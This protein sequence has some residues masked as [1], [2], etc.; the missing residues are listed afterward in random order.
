MKRTKFYEV[1]K[2][3]GAKLIEYGGFEM[4]VQ[5]S[6]IITEHKSVRNSVGIFDVSHMGEIFVLGEN[7]LDFVQEIAINDV[8]KLYPG[9]VQYSA[10]CKPNGGIIDDLLVYRLG[11]NEFMLVVNASNTDKDFQWMNSNIKTGVTLEN[12]S[13]EYSLLAVQ[14]PCSKK[15]IQKL[16]NCELDNLEYYH[17][18]KAKVA[19]IDV[20]LSRTG[21]TGEL[22][23]ELYLTGDEQKATELWDKVIDA[24]KEYDIQPLGLAARDSL[25]LEMGFCLYGNDIDE[26]TNPLEAGL[27]WITKLSKPKF[28]G[29][30]ALAEIKFRGVERKLSGLIS[31]DKVFPRHGYE[32]YSNGKKVGYIT[33]GTVSPVLEK[34]IALG[35]LETAYLFEGSKIEISVRGRKFAAN[36]V[37]VPFIKK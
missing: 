26:T 13:D 21:Y 37:K 6:S 32:I 8:S 34:P 24:G 4:P 19:E 12:R 29:K 17:F 7:A 35:Y 31:T 25:R 1:H 27:G 33:S 18:I 16:T 22:G 14:G 2:R 30:E 11:D 36:V 10:M 23:Y 20:I 15:V 5:Y 28:I 3:L 9:R